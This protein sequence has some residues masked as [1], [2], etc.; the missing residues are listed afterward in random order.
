MNKEELDL[1]I[2]NQRA[3]FKAGK[4]LDINTR[5]A[6]LKLLKKSIKDNEKDLLEA[7][8]LDLGKSHDEGYMCE[9]G[10]VYDELNYMIKHIKKR[11]ETFCTAGTGVC[12]GVNKPAFFKKTYFYIRSKLFKSAACIVVK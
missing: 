5:K 3:Y 12:A 8:R 2:N 9:V 1:L 10:L 7:L 11:M 6:K 4:T